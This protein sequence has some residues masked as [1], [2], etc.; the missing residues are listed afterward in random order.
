MTESSEPTHLPDLPTLSVPMDAEA[1]VAKLDK[2]SRRGRLPGFEP[3]PAGGLFLVDAWGTPFDHD[4]V[5]N[6]EPDDSGTQLRFL[7]R[8]RR[9]MPTI[10][11]VILLLTIWP[12]VWLTDSM[13]KIWFNWYYTLTQKDIFI[14]NGFEWFTYGWYLPLCVVP[15]P[16]FWRSIMRRSRRTAAESALEMIAKISK[17]LGVT[18]PPEAARAL[19]A[20][21]SPPA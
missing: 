13:L 15:L 10:H 3:K 9:R 14:F 1:I 7:L 18:P 5:A 16:W 8:M 17:E 11:A 2:A 19:E 20:V 21:E 6:A 4:L 12:G